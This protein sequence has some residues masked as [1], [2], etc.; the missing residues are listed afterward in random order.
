MTAMTEIPPALA[1]ALE[2]KGYEQLTPVQAAV[3]DPEVAGRDLLV[4]AQTGSGKTVAFG[5]A[6]AG[7]LLAETPEL[8]QAGRPRALI[9]APTRELAMQVRAELGWLYAG[10]KGQL[11]TCVGGMD[12]RAERRALERG[13]HIVVGTPGRLRDHIERGALDLSEIEIAVLDEAD[14]ML[15]MGFREDLEFI[16]EGAPDERRT[17]LFSATVP[18]AIERLA[19]TYQNNA[20][21][22]AVQ[23]EGR[24]H[25]DIAYR[26]L[27]VSPSDRE[28]AVINLLRY[29]EAES[30]IIFCSTRE[31]VSRLS[32]KLGNRG[33]AAVMLS[34]EMDQSA[35]THALQAMR[36]K[37]A[38]VCVATD[39]AARGIDLPG[40]ELVIHADLP[41]NSETL[42][43]RSGRTGRAGRKGVCVLIAPHDKRR[44]AK[45]LLDFAKLEAEWGAPPTLEEVEA[46]DRERWLADPALS[47]AG[48]ESDGELIAQ[49]AANFPPEQLAAAF[50]AAKRA[51]QPAA[52]ELRSGFALGEPEGRKPRRENEG[53]QFEGGVWYRA[54][55]GRKHRAEPRW[56]LPMICKLGGITRKQVG[57]IEI[58]ERESRFEIE[59]RVAESFAASLEANGG[60][61]NKVRVSLIDPNAEAQDAPA[62]APAAAPAAAPDAAPAAAPVETAPEAPAAEAAPAPERKPIRAPRPDR[63][64]E[65]EFKR[66]F[67]RKPRRDEDSRT[68][69]KSDYKTG[70]RK[71]PKAGP[72]RDHRP[73]EGP[74]RKF[75]RKPR[76]EGEGSFERKPRRDGE[77]G[78]ERKPR[79]EGEGGYEGK[80]PRGA[81]GWKGKPRR[82][83]GDRPRRGPSDKPRGKPAGEGGEDSTL[84]KVRRA[85]RPA[86][87]GPGSAPPKR[88]GK[89]FGKDDRK[90]SGGPKGPRRPRPTDAGS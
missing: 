67:E 63:K 88:R 13:A 61:E 25:A 22:L 15:D 82:D 86:A 62:V 23:G 72:K 48:E 11:A 8:G 21:R 83:E 69:P 70:H 75:E 3:L 40:L 79:R 76:R 24:A 34:G 7:E 39:V 81:E 89:P 18:R 57:R 28:N 36:D 29:E 20:L 43:H 66:K 16:L 26:V 2:E 53:P 65:G 51:A 85:P 84:R 32:A 59:G 50:V 17:L 12:P 35:R 6:M 78:Y 80:R 33:F 9:I 44:K 37:R 1:G 31:G 42:L 54:T 77:G 4:S 46:R 49:L 14:E 60:G 5:L 90:P 30:A 41:I 87:G 55:V 71:G 19:E 27:S 58:R 74:P 52:E 10:A 68:E 45:R 56:L 47:E 73:G 38:R 64:P